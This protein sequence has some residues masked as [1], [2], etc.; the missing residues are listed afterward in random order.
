MLFIKPLL[1]NISHD[2]EAESLG[3]GRGQGLN[4]WNIHKLTVYAHLRRNPGSNMQIGGI[5]LHHVP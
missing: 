4:I 2:A 3:I 1:L 5:L